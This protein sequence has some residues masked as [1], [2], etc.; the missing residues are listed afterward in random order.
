M[1]I[2]ILPGLNVPRCHDM[3]LL[4]QLRMPRLDSNRQSKSGEAELVSAAPSLSRNTGNRL[5]TT[6]GGD[7]RGGV[8][9]HVVEAEESTKN[10]LLPPLLLP[11][12]VCDETT[13]SANIGGD[14]ADTFAILSLVGSDSGN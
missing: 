4:I 2:S 12:E 8:L 10:L 7:R 11:H 13:G 6:S 3:Y 9:S 14:T 1:K 5:S